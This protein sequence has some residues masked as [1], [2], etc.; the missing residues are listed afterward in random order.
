MLSQDD[1][2]ALYITGGQG[3]WGQGQQMVLVALVGLVGSHCEFQC[4][5]PSNIQASQIVNHC[6]PPSRIFQGR[7]DI[8]DKMHHFFKSNNG[9]RTYVLHGLGCWQ[10]TDCS[11]I[12]T[13][14]IISLLKHLFY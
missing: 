14:V 8:L 5:T 3:S 13:R 6:A 1:S 12:H 11:E 7:R 9:S 10:D 2:R 4:A